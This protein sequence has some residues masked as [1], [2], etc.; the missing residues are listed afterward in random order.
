MSEIQEYTEASKRLIEKALASG[1]AQMLLDV[2]LLMD[3]VSK[4]ELEG[5]ND[6]TNVFNSQRLRHS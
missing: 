2:K 3:T 4:L 1:D 5:E 6:E